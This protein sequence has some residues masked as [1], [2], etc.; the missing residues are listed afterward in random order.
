MLPDKAIVPN[1]AEG[2]LDF[3]Q[4]HEGV[5]LPTYNTRDFEFVVTLL[6]CSDIS[7]EIAGTTPTSTKDDRDPHTK[8]FVEFHLLGIGENGRRYNPRVQLEDYRRK[9]IGG[10]LRVDPALLFNTAR[11]VRSLVFDSKKTAS[12]G[13]K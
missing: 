9:Y 4:E 8:T 7:I 13:A 6:A 1:D 2:P 10:E 12:G 11:H 3:E 5:A